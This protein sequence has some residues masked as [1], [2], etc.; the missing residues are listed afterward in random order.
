MITVKSARFLR[1]RCIHSHCGHPSY[2]V[3]ERVTIALRSMSK[4]FT[5]ICKWDTRTK[6]SP[7]TPPPASCRGGG[8]SATFNPGFRPTVSSV[9]CCDGASLCLL[10]SPDRVTAPVLCHRGLRM[11]RSFNCW[12]QWMTPLSSVARSD[13]YSTSWWN[14]RKSER[15]VGGGCLRQSVNVELFIRK[16]YFISK[17]RH[18]TRRG[19]TVRTTRLL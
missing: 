13:Y 19:D 11:S 9:V 7:P 10:A 6:A 18:M 15:D 3:T 1:S 5:S 17:F 4:R 8:P 12:S 2:L 14:T 16:L